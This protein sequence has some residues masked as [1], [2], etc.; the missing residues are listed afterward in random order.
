MCACVCVCVCACVCVTR[1]YIC[2]SFMEQVNISCNAGFKHAGAGTEAPRCLADGSFELGRICAPADY[3][4]MWL[5][6][7]GLV[8]GNLAGMCISLFFAVA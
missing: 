8:L 4:N 1:T 3:G 2:V 5:V 7:I 6:T